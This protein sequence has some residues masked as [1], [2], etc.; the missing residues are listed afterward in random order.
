MT[1]ITTPGEKEEA[2]FFLVR[3]SIG[4]TCNCLKPNYNSDILNTGLNS[5]PVSGNA[6]KPHFLWLFEYL[7]LCYSM[8]T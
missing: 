7:D 1:P 8:F 3:R 6:Y 2:S 5:G 4:F